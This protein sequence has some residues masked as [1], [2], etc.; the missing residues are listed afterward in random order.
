MN[1]RPNPKDIDCACY[2]ALSVLGIK[3]KYGIGSL[4]IDENFLGCIGL[5]QGVHPTF[6]RVNPNIGVHSLHLMKL[7]AD[8]AGEKYRRGE[9]PT[10]SYPLGEACPKVKQFIFETEA[11]VLPEAKRLADTIKKYG[12]PY[13]QSLASYGAMLPRIR[14]RVAGPVS[15]THLTLPTNREV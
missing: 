3:K 2:D 12:I 15:Y 5:N 14:Q 10:L 11:D 8:A 7:V 6:V 4:A 9:Y 1:K 13:I